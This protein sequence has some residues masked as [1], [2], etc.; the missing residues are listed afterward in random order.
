MTAKKKTG[1][2][3]ASNLNGRKVE[4]ENPVEGLT[5]APSQIHGFGCFATRPFARGRKIAEYTG[6][7]LRWK[8]VTSEEAPWDL[9]YLLDLDPEWVIDGSRGGNQT[10]YINHSCESNVF[11]RV[12]RGHAIFYA[13]RDI[14]P[15]EELTWCYFLM[16]EDGEQAPCYC[17]SDPI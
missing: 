15:G 1:K 17:E 11:M 10:R 16:D 8:D 12:T 5:V 9:N 14:A 13:L 7:R 6:A 2:K 3:R 4:I